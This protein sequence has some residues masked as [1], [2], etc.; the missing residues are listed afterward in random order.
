[1][2]LILKK[3]LLNTNQTNR[4]LS[5]KFHT[6]KLS[7]TT[8]Y[9]QI[10]ALPN[11]QI[12]YYI[13]FA[14]ISYYLFTRVTLSS[15]SVVAFMFISLS[16]YYF[17]NNK[18]NT[19]TNERLTFDEKL[20]YLETFLF[21]GDVFNIRKNPNEGTLNVLPNNMPPLN[22]SYL[23]TSLPVVE[24]YYSV[25]ELSQY[26]P[27]NYAASLNGMNDLLKLNLLMKV[28]ANNPK[29]TIDLAKDQATKCL[30]ALQAIILSL[31]SDPTYN[32]FFDNSLASL[33]RL[34]NLYLNAMTNIAKK[35][36]DEQYKTG[37]LNINSHQI[38][39]DAPNPNDTKAVNFSAHYNQ[40]Y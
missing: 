17:L 10:N 2:S 36:Y 15:S 35:E 26:N 1:M 28:G 30:N 9:D 27:A 18:S 6:D 38:I 22:K 32:K 37:N 3:F 12:F 4:E 8:I 7:N 5:E 21:N 29:Q 16:M 33:Q 24:F 23:H 19:E 40:Y 14:I 13:L 39:T 31:P 20:Q 25:R 11:E 34:T